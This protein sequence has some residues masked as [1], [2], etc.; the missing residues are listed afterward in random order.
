VDYDATMRIRLV[1]PVLMVVLLGACSGT[2]G[3]ASNAVPSTGGK[4]SAAPQGASP[5]PAG[6]GNVDCAKIKTAA[7]QLLAVQ[8]LAQLRTPDS[9]A[10]IKAKTIGNLDLDAFVAGMHDLHALD[11]FASPLGDPKAA[12]DFY[13][14]AAAAAQ[15][16][17]ATDPMTQ[18][19]IDAYTAKVGTVPDILSHQVAIS[20]AMG[21][22]GC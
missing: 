14:A 1:A 8:L 21:A 18:A 5:A 22:A 3:A 17:L 6:N 12:I 19:A 11:A 16:L 20:G 9:I 7:Q 10:S 15:D 2:G 13:E 4:A